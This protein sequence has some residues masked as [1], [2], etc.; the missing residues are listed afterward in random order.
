MLVS[1]ALTLA[2]ALVADWRRRDGMLHWGA[3]LALHTLAY[4]CFSLRGT[5][6]DLL[7]VLLPNMLL[8]A[9]F[10]LFGEGLCQFQERRPPRWALWAPVGVCAAAFALL[11]QH[12]TPRL[13]AGSLILGAQTVGLLA[14]LAQGRRGTCGRG[15]YFVAAGL[16]SLLPVFALRAV[17][18]WH[19]NPAL[20]NLHGSEPLQVLTFLV[21]LANTLLTGLGFVLMTKERADRQ[22]HLLA[23]SD[24]LTGLPNRRFTLQSLDRELAIAR[25][26]R[27]PLTVLMLDI[28]H[29][30]SVNDCH[31]HLAGDAVLRWL[32]A[33]LRARLRAQDLLGRIGGEEFLALLP[34]TPAEGA[35][36]V[37][38]EALRLAV[39]AEACT[40]AGAGPVAVTLSAGV[41]VWQPGSAAGARELMAA[42]DHALYRAKQSGRNRVELARTDD[43]TC[44]PPAP[45]APHTLLPGALPS[46]PG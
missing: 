1:A 8:S 32:A 9:T 30:K 33:L 26:T 20:A 18:V 21:V 24:E 7:T 22:N 36:L 14:L 40:V 16:L 31:G 10:A 17:A 19:G 38:A 35:G 34:A 39:A 43:Y 44:A 46:L 23:L 25:R 45:P 12:S 2:M 5:V 4:G 27:K 42:S 41:A 11:L 6:P 3:G 13:L 15:Q 37:L 29:F 28:D